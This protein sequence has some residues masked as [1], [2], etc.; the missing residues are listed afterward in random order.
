MLYFKSETV[1]TFITSRPGISEPALNEDFVHKANASWGSLLFPD[2]FNNIIK[3]YNT[4]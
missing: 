2:Q 4:K 3:R 1:L